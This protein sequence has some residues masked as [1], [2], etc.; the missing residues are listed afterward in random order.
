MNDYISTAE[1][2]RYTSSSLGRVE[3]DGTGHLALESSD[4]RDG[5][6]PGGGEDDDGNKDEESD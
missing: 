2:N 3:T 4:G 6:N 1:N 5:G